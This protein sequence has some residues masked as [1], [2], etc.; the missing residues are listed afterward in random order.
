LPPI[1]GQAIVWMYGVPVLAISLSTYI[2]LNFSRTNKELQTQLNR[3]KQ[4]SEEKLQQERRAKEEEIQRRILESDNARKTKELE[5]ARKL[6][7]SM[8]PK[9]VPK[10]PGLDIAVSMK[11]ASEVGGDYYDFHA[12]DGV[13]TVVIGDATGHGMRAGTMVA[14]IKSLFSANG[15]IEQLP[16]TLSAWSNIIR[17][18]NLGNLY[19]AMSL[20][21]IETNR[22]II[23]NA[24]MP[25]AMLYR[26]NDK[27]VEEIVLKSMPLGG[28]LDYAYDQQTV[29]VASGDTLLLMSDGLM[30]LFNMDSE[31]YDERTMPT[32]TRI[33]HRSPQEIINSL[34]RECLLWRGERPQND[35]IT[36]VVVKFL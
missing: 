9:K 8:L 10:I 23:A 17:Q 1:G 12:N 3:V 33:A 7:L 14:A 6:Q 26:A 36:F 13:L 35:D 34:E 18:M 30:E 2:S 31:M 25:P 19:M 20:L 27:K 22:M 4:L 29:S 32:F 11:T 15:N 21:R 24:G 28:A 5:E 16:E